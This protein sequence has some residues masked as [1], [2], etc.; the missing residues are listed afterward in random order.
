MESVRPDSLLLNIVLDKW[1]VT[2]HKLSGDAMHGW[3]SGD[4][5]WIVHV[6]LV[7]EFAIERRGYSG[8]QKANYFGAR[9]LNNGSFTRTYARRM[10]VIPSRIN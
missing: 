5:I 8:T 3:Y 6:N 1:T 10:E 2:G 4:C 7:I 9:Y